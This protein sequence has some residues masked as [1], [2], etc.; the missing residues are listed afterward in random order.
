MMGRRFQIAALFSRIILP[1]DYQIFHVAAIDLRE[2]GVV[3][4][5]PLAPI[6]RP[7]ELWSGRSWVLRR[8]PR[9]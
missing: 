2:G 5:R 1:G 4:L 7:V 8:R 6:D 3:I 9:R